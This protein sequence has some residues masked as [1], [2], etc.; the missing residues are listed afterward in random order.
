[1]TDSATCLE[2]LG[3]PIFTSRSSE[4]YNWEADKL[5]KLFHPAIDADLIINEEINSQ[6][7]FA[8]GVSGVECCG[9]VQVGDRQGLILKK[10]AGKTLISLAASKPQTVF[11]VHRL[12]ADL[13]IALHAAKSDRIRSYKG[14]VKEAL[15][16][17]PMQFLTA[18]EKAHCLA[19]LEALPEGKQILHL[20]YHPDNIMSDGKSQTTIIDWMTAAA[21]VPAADVAATLFLLNEGE[22]IPGMSKLA[23]A[24]LEAIRKTVCRKYYADYKKKTGLTDQEVAR[25]RLPFLIFRLTIW[26]IESE[27]PGLQSKIREELAK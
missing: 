15:D 13:Q 2:D 11:S 20:D 17:E 22:M 21:G 23:G 3:E 16:R 10:V 18:G 6:E 8:L 25:W 5:L 12:M 26:N 27:R 9:R 7:T 24:A 4:I 19:K 1:M 14:F